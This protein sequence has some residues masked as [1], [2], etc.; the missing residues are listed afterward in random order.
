[1]VR[2]KQR[3][4]ETRFG[5][6]N[7]RSLYRAGLLVAAAR[8]VVGCRLDLVAVQEVRWDRESSVRAGDYK[9]FYGRGNYN[10]QLGKGPFVHQRITSAVTKV[11]YVIDRVSYVVLRGRWCSIIVLN[12]HATSEKKS[13]D[14]KY[15]F[16]EE[17][18]QF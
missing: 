15:S 7:V 17:L 11:A 18:E 5:T 2:S 6:W 9:F 4:R 8:E 13:D 3:K 1:M 12:V 14:S 10:H 16:Y